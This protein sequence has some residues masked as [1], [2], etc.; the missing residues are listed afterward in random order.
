MSCIYIGIDGHFYL[1]VCL[2]MLFQTILILLIFDVFDTFDLILANKISD[3]ICH[4]KAIRDS[5]LDFRINLDSDP[6][7]CGSDRPSVC[8]CPKTVPFTLPAVPRTADFV[9][10]LVLLTGYQTICQTL[11]TVNRLCLKCFYIT[12]FLLEAYVDTRH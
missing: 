6:D 12:T 10:I 3:L 11:F 2:F 8:P 9:I 7:V 4:P 1:V 5:N